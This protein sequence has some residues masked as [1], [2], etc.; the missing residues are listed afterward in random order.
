MATTAAAAT[1]TSNAFIA[2]ARLAVDEFALKD[3]ADRRIEKAV[4]TADRV[5]LAHVDIFAGHASRIDVHL[6]HLADHQRMPVGAE[7]EHAF[8]LALEMDRHLLDPWR[9]DLQARDRGE[10]GFGEFGIPFG[11]T[12]G[13][14]HHLLPHRLRH[15]VEAELAGLADVLERMLFAAV[16]IARDG[17]RDH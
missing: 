4:E 1:T 8:E 3:L 12:V 17:Q 5:E 9:L 11:K 2:L 14:V 10:P 13:A 15:H 7:L 16:G 6:D